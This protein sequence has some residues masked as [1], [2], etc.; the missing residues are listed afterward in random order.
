MYGLALSAGLAAASAEAYTG[1]IS[2]SDRTQVGR[3]SRNGIPQDFAGGEG[4]FPGIVN[5]TVTYYYETF[6]VNTGNTPYLSVTIDTPTG[7]VF[8]SAY[9]T[10]YA[11]DSDTTAN[12]G[13]QTNWLGD[14]GSSNYV[15][16]LG[17][18]GDP[19]YFD[20]VAAPNSTVYIVV[21]TT[22]AAGLGLGDTFSLYVQGSTD[23]SYDNQVDLSV[24]RIPEPSTVVLLL[25]PLGLM[26]IFRRRR[27]NAAH[28]ATQELLAA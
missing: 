1:S 9:Q 13:F 12:L 5:P 27:P 19:G 6:A 26:A 14:A 24:S 17:T 7:N 16:F 28:R 11:P 22:G 25:A 23:V 21:N 2:S 15:F 18:P 20:V 10:S 3:I 4:A 8:G